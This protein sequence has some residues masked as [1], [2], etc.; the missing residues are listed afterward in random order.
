MKC[1]RMKSIMN[2][3]FRRYNNITLIKKTFSY[4]YSE[5]N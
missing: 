3:Q 2:C 4:F 5:N 1:N